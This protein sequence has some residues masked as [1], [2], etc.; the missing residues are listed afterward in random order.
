[1]G[2]TLGLGVSINCVYI[3]TSTRHPAETMGLACSAR[4]G[5][6]WVQGKAA[7]FAPALMGSRSLALLI[8]AKAPAGSWPMGMSPWP[9]QANIT[10][11]GT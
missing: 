3:S 7:T 10:G 6:M 1:M 8:K 2:L 11:C 9:A 4:L 5:F